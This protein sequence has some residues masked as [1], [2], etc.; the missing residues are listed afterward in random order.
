MKSR[1]TKKK[2]LTLVTASTALALL[3]GVSGGALAATTSTLP[4]SG[5]LL[6][7]NTFYSFMYIAENTSV[8]QMALNTAGMSGV[9]L[10][11]GGS[12]ANLDSFIQSGNVS[13]AAFS[14]YAS[15]H[16]AT[17]PS[18]IAVDD[19]VNGTVTNSTYSTSIST[20]T[21]NGAASFNSMAVI[22]LQITP[23]LG[24]RYANVTGML[25]SNGM[26]LANTK[27]TLTTTATG[28]TF[29]ASMVT[30]AS[31]QFRF[32]YDT[33]KLTGE[34]TS[35]PGTSSHIYSLSLSI[36]PSSSGTGSGA[37]SK[38]SIDV[39]NLTITPNITD[40]Y[41]T[42]T[43]TVLSNGLP[44][45]NTKITLTTT[46][47]RG[48]FPASVVTNGNGQFSFMYDTN[49]LTG[50]L[51]SLQGTSSLIYNLSLSFSPT[52]SSAG[53][54]VSSTNSI[55]ISNCQVSRNPAN[56]NAIV[57]GTLF[58]NGVPLANTMINL[59]TTNRGVVPTSVI[60]NGSGQFSFTYDPS[61]TTGTIN[62]I[63]NF[64]EG[65]QQVATKSVSYV[66]SGTV[67][68]AVAVNNIPADEAF[69]PRNGDVYV[70]D[71]GNDT[72]SV[73]DGNQD[74][75]TQNTVVANVGVGNAPQGVTYDSNNSRVYVT[76]SGSNTVSVIN[77]S[78]N[79][80]VAT[81]DGLG[82]YPWG[83]AYDASNG[84]VY[85]ADLSS[86]TISV[87]D[88]TTNHV[89]T[90]VN[91]GN[92]PAELAYDASTGDI[93]VV[94]EYF[95]SSN[96][97]VSVIDSTTN[98]VIATVTVGKGPNGIAYD[99]SNGDLYV[100]NGS[101]NTVSV[102]DGNQGDRTANTVIATVKGNGLDGLDRVAYGNGSLYVTNAGS[103]TVSV[104]DPQTNSLLG[105]SIAVG[106]H[107]YGIVYD[108]FN[109]DLYV[110]NQ[111]YNS[112][113][114]TYGPGSVSVIKN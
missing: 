50:E 9:A 58:S 95:G 114:A 67:V 100:T 25:T 72:V 70:A 66:I 17:I 38:N 16:P 110:S 31:G 109:G 20:S 42:V 74:S 27:V 78:T 75:S 37:L 40:S 39:S 8:V 15:T 10:D 81:I 107:P 59:T 64:N 79:K 29:P 69:S 7:G 76:N 26:P 28:S 84:D 97:T 80:I 77:T 73:I 23:L 94:N 108:P 92:Q 14:N 36:S 93:Y 56:A 91:V 45:A 52:S 99:S 87:I 113:L 12:I 106:G 105:N 60:T 111:N 54:G 46:T 101:D 62:D 35:L 102:I 48:V 96:G 13:N 55:G 86:N 88:G 41:A 11:L 24:G 6:I 57:S 5:G 18:G 68:A 83:D 30:N 49:K 3:V 2:K 89:V 47:T 4:S 65:A 53:S 103:N 104:I 98:T 44:L 112:S 32:M 22:N 90:T 61:Q 85:V 51:T 34:L 63:I 43:G 19:V 33:S 1:I 82:M 21:G 71:F